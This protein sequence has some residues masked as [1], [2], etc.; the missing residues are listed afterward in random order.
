MAR[1]VYCTIGALSLHA[2]ALAA[3]LLV[4]VPSTDTIDIDAYDPPLA[5]TL[6]DVPGDSDHVS[7]DIAGADLPSSPASAEPPRPPSPPSKTGHEPNARPLASRTSPSSRPSNA[8]AKTGGGSEAARPAGLFG[9][10]GDRSAADFATAFTRGFPQAASTDPQ[11]ASATL[12]SAG[13]ADVVVTLGEDGHVEHTEIRG[14]PTAALRA[15]ISR[16]MSLIGRRPFTSRGRITTLHLS[17]RVTRDEIHDGLHGD[18]FAIGASFTGS[19]HAFFALA[20]G[21]RI[22]LDIVAK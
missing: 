7:P 1:L 14:A 20:I 5:G 21:R 17:S 6:E 9:A 10:I 12:G 3:A 11:W 2:L 15:G 4:P 13:S 16:T 19:G 22:D 18:V 8:S